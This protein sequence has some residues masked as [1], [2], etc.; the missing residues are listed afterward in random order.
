MDPRVM[1]RR[2]P[3]PAP[4][5]APFRG[6]HPPPRRCGRAAGRTRPSSGRPGRRRPRTCC[7][8]ANLSA[9]LMACYGPVAEAA[10]QQPPLRG[11]APPPTSMRASAAE[12]PAECGRDPCRIKHPKRHGWTLLEPAPRV[13]ALGVGGVPVR[14]CLCVVRHL[15]ILRAAGSPKGRGR[16][17]A[18]KKLRCGIGLPSGIHRCEGRL[19]PLP[20][21]A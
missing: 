9:Q 2:G 5:P 18:G 7:G 20:P 8:P 1:H 21:S 4:R 12:T 11:E 15:P 13:I 6:P 10:I 3:G 19:S 17:R 14:R 16:L